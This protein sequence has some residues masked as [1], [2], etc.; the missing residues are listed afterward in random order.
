MSEAV[1][2]A[3][4]AM[5]PSNVVQIYAGGANGVYTRTASGAFIQIL[6][7]AADQ[8]YSWQFIRFKTLMI[9][10][11][12]DTFPKKTTVG[13]TD[14]PVILG[15]TPPRAACGAMVGD[16]LVLG[17]LLEDPDDGGAFAPNRIRWSGIKNIDAPWITDPATQA[18][19][20][21]LP[22]EGGEVVAVTGRTNMT[23][24]QERKISFGRYVNLPQVW[25]I[26]PVEDDVGC[27]ARDS[28]VSVGAFKF[29][30][31]LDGFRVWNGT[32]SERIGDGKID[33]YFFSRLQFSQRNKISGAYDAATNCIYWAF[34]TSLA[35]TLGEIIIYSPRTNRFSHSTQVVECLFP[36]AVSTLTVE[37][38]VGF[39]DDNPGFVDDPSLIA[40][41]TPYLGAFNLSHQYGLYSG[42][43]SDAGL[44]TGEFSGPD[45]RRV[46]VNKARPIVDLLQPLA[47]VQTI[48]RDQLMGGP[49][50]YG[51]AV[52][53]EIDGTCPILSEARYMRFLVYIPAGAFWKHAQGVEINRKAGGQF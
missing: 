21:D 43:P 46:F 47:S 48:G 11:H 26:E 16:F 15:G 49:V 4:A 10:L 5:L 7:Q 36:S 30:I 53:Q 17:N 25:D 3:I 32:N 6:S 31:A 41:G 8:S 24:F 45:N 20:T 2:G 44:V 52:G 22:P 38:L 1:H 37:D 23:I 39:T 14:T 19:Y 27:I 40:G 34:P 35:G 42:L 50:I 28:V 12:R 18:D 13:T 33:K 51:S 29:F 9:A